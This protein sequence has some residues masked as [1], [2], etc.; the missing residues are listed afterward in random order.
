[1]HPK[2]QLPF[3]LIHNATS[4]TARQ[5][6]LL[7]TSVP[8]DGKHEAFDAGDAEM[9]IRLLCFILQDILHDENDILDEHRVYV[10]HNCLS[11][12]KRMSTLTENLFLKQTFDST[13]L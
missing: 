12:E 2:P 4:T 5:Q 10:T 13:K 7:T 8:N 11:I 1:M 6:A 3:P 9:I